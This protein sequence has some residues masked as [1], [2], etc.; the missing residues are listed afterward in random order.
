MVNKHVLFADKRSTVGYKY[1][2]QNLKIN[3]QTDAEQ[4]TATLLRKTTN[5]VKETEKIG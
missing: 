4:S 1:L 5:K 3:Q 2:R